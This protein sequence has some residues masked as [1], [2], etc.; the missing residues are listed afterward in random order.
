MLYVHSFLLSQF[1]SA[2][3]HQISSPLYHNQQYL[4]HYEYLNQPV[5]NRP[6]QGQATHDMLRTLASGMEERPVTPRH[7]VRECRRLSQ[8]WCVLTGPDGTRR[9]ELY[10][11]YDAYFGFHLY[12]A[13]HDPDVL[14]GYVNP[15]NDWSLTPD[16]K[17]A[18]DQPD[19]QLT[20][21]GQFEANLLQTLRVPVQPGS[22]TRGGTRDGGGAGAG[23][24]G[25]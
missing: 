14:K 21:R 17:R 18:C 16:W 10:W 24:R 15:G 2:F 23:R 13:L 8:D 3:L 22:G 9:N 1:F 6:I 4:N 20:N 11:G 7:G 12:Y 19:G 25:G 5:F